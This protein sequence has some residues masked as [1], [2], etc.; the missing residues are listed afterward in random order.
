[1]R[2]ACERLR[3]RRKLGTAMEASNAMMATTIMISTEREAATVGF[4]VK[5]MHNEWIDG[6]DFKK[7]MQTV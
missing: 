4:I 1:M 7:Q 3:A 6:W 5:K 2:V